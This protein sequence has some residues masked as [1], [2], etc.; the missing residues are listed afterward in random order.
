[1]RN[2]YKTILLSSICCLLAASACGEKDKHPPEAELLLTVSTKEILLDLDK[3]NEEVLTLSWN[4]VFESENPNTIHY[5]LEI[6]KKGN[7]FGDPMPVFIGRSEEYAY[8]FTHKAF[9]SLLKDKAM[10]VGQ[11]IIYEVRL[12]ADCQKVI[13]LC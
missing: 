11:T 1:M 7:M 5:L 6:D 12:I 2:P 3:G 13:P 4:R 8:S 9:Y 10:A